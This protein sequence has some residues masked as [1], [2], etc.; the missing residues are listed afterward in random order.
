MFS[1]PTFAYLRHIQLLLLLLLSCCCSRTYYLSTFYQ[2]RH[3]AAATYCGN[4]SQFLFLRSL[5]STD[6]SG[7]EV[8]NKQEAEPIL[9]HPLAAAAHSEW[10]PR[11]SLSHSATL[12]SGR[13]PALRI[14]T[15]SSRLFQPETFEQ[16]NSEH[17]TL[18]PCFSSVPSSVQ[19]QQRHSIHRPVQ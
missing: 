7:A 13:I 9:G 19:S 4:T 5:S 12:F 11:R 14:C 16:S 6:L 2:N 10:E 18:R 15:G 3:P 1:N 8:N 17:H